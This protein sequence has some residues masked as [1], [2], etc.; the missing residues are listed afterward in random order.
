MRTGLLITAAL[1]ALSGAGQALGQ[2]DPFGAL[3]GA[4]AAPS[5]T[6]STKA[7]G[8]VGLSYAG[9][10][11]GGMTT[12]LAQIDM[13][14]KTAAPL[15]PVFNGYG[16]KN[17]KLRP[18]V[19]IGSYGFAF[20]Q[21]MSATATALGRGSD[22]TPRRTSIELKLSGFSDKLGQDL[23]DEAYKD[24]AARLAAAGFD[25]VPADQV[26]AASSYQALNTYPGP[27]VIEGAQVST[28][29]VYGRS[30]GPLV[31]GFAFESG[32]ASIQPGNNIGLGKVSQE[33][34]AVVLLPRLLVDFARLES[35]GR[36]NYT[37]S[38]NVGAELRFRINEA[39]RADF[40]AGNDRGGSMPGGWGLKSGTGTD[41]AFA[42]MN[43][44]E[45]RSDSVGLHNAMAMAGMGSVYRQSVTYDVAISQA[46]YATLARAA[47][48]GF[49]AALVAQIRAAK[50]S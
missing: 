19:A 29:R 38:A 46:R 32:M 48:Q 33:L 21:A 13:L 36:S 8:A 42:V 43:Q 50:G 37:A 25:V 47:Y 24:L 22:I 23:A 12:S 3:Y 2:S 11:T 30:G 1:A 16:E 7:S 6:G 10:N 5:K 15:A 35:S 14:P 45:D 31:K 17:L 41:E 40:V 27:F 20:T 34:D 49:N 26:V 28:K 18:K 9:H 4:Q 39:S 44:V